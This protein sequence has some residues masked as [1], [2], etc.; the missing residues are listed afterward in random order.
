MDRAHAARFRALSSS[1]DRESSLSRPD[2][3]PIL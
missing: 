1:G 2:R 3:S